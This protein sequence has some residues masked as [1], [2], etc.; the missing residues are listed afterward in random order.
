MKTLRTMLLITALLIAGALTSQTV[1]ETYSMSYFAGQPP[2]AISAYENDKGIQYLI[3]GQ[4]MGN[5]ASVQLLMS[6]S[7]I[8]DFHKAVVEAGEKFTSWSEN[9]K[10]KGLN[11]MSK[12]MDIKST[13]GAGFY[14][15]E[16]RFDFNV[17]LEFRFQVIKGNPLL[18]I[19]SGKLQSSSNEYITSDGLAI[20][21]TG[22][23]IPGFI[24]K[25]NPANLKAKFI[26]LEDGFE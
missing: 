13:C 20:A 17:N 8:S 15:S 5:D 12:T 23:E 6:R 21:L 9:A 2:Y 10:S 3:T 11:D 1:I 22:A 26:A 14:S 18:V 19:A 25:V 7:Q 4:A 24:Y 16:W